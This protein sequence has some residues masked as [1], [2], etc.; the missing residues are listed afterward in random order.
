MASSINATT[1]T[2]VV[3]SSD[4][5]GALALQT[6]GTTA[7]TISSAQ[8]VNFVNSFTV[9]GSPLASSAM[10]LIT[11]TTASA[12]SSVDFTG[13]SATYKN[14]VVMITNCVLSVDTEFLAIRTSIDNGSTFVSAAASYAYRTMMSQQGTVTSS[15]SQSATYINPCASFYTSSTANAGGIN[16]TITIVNPSNA[17]VTNMYGTLS[18]YYSGTLAVITFSGATLATAGVVN[19]IR[20]YPLTG[21]ITSGTFKLYGIS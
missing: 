19:A 18:S 20:F 7:M 8:V 17:S 1:T 3:V 4:T 12:S 16:G 21:N 9:A 10:T 11:T 13:L 2:G 6:G 5:S 15:G 14:Y